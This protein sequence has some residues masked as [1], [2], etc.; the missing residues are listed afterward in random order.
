[1]ICTRNCKLCKNIRFVPTPS[2]VSGALQLELGNIDICNNEK[3]CFVISGNIPSSNTPIPV[4]LVIND[5]GFSYIN[6]CGNYVYSDQIT[7]RTIYSIS[8]K[9]DTLL[10]QNLKCNL[11]PTSATVPCIPVPKSVEPN[12]STKVKVGDVK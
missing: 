11:Y 4:K 9:T 2:I 10:A 1:M 7:S 5:V 3:L 6:K 8:V 12:V